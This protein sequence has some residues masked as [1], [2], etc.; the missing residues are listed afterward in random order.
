MKVKV[1]FILS[2]VVYLIG[3]FL[4][5]EAGK[6]SS[7]QVQTVPEAEKPSEW[8]DHNGHNKAWWMNQVMIWKDKKERA[9]NTLLQAKEA[10]KL[11]RFKNFSATQKRIARKQLREEIQTHTEEL[12]KAEAMLHTT[13]PEQARRA[14]VP[15]GWLR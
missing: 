3:D 5:V 13:L 2:L 6:V 7:P 15:A 11:T 14:G 12:R 4:P 1:F 9:R 8:L 10:F